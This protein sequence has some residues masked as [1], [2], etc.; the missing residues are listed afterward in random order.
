MRRILY[1]VRHAEAVTVRDGTDKLRAL[2]QR[3]ESDALQLA[4]Y[5][6]EK[7]SN[8][9]LILTSPATRALTTAQIIARQL[10]YDLK[11]IRV[12]DSIYSARKLEILKLLTNL[13]D[14][15]HH[16]VLVGH[17]PTIVELY[18]YLSEND[19]KQTMNPAEMCS[20][21]FGVPWAE[22]TAGCGVS[23]MYFHPSL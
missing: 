2:T 22:V 17:Y 14:S 15:I 9:N 6:K 16:V 13:A 12:E 3:G 5:I 20:L 23:N 4:T 18:N 1:L 10:S 7:N 8:L 11:N 21:A 19:S